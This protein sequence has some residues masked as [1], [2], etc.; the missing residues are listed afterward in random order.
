VS[1]NQS[2]DALMARLQAGDGS[3]EQLFDRF[4]D[5]WNG[6][7]PPRIEDHL[8]PPGAPGRLAL[9]IELA[10]IDLERRL[11]AGEAARV[12]SYLERFPELAAD[13]AAVAL[14]LR[15]CALRRRSEPG[16]GAAEYLA[17]FPQY[18][19]AI[20]AGLASMA[21]VPSTIRTS[22]PAAAVPPGGGCDLADANMTEAGAAAGGA[23]PD[24]LGLPG[25]RS[26][27]ALFTT[28][29][30]PRPRRRRRRRGGDRRGGRHA[31]AAQRA[32][33][34]GQHFPQAGPPGP[35]ALRLSGAGINPGAPRRSWGRLRTRGEPGGRF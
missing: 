20:L 11:K 28:L 24:R 23:G 15:E 31:A 8:P 19:E 16:L 6:P 32:G 27:S 25:Y 13:P 21:E 12:E 4:E 22:P 34:P 26:S 1:P 18:R 2:F 10:H 5:A 17:R 29:S 30:T 9:L 35:A 33:R 3:L 14:I 7:A